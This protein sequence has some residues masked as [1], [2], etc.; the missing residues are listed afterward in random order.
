MKVELSDFG[1]VKKGFS[2]ELDQDEILSETD[3]V[4]R[5]LAARV[6][7]P[8]FRA[9]KAPLSVIRTRFASEIESDVVESLVAR[10]HAEAAEK[11]GLRPL[12][13]PVIEDLNHD[14]GSSLRFRTTFEV[15]PEVAPKGYRGVEVREPAVRITVE[16]VEKA[17][18]ELRD[19][20][21]KL[22]VEE[23]R[24]ARTG[25]VIVA[26]I[27][28]VPASGEPFRRERSL[29]EVGAQDNLP[30]F[31]ERIDGAVAGSLL[32]FPVR[33]PEDYPASHLAGQTVQYKL[34]IHE[35]KTRQLPPL[36]DDFARDLGDFAGLDALRERIRQDLEQARR[37][38]A[39]RAVRAAVLDKV[40]LEN[41]IPLPDVL[42]E[43]EVQARLQDM[44]LSLMMQGVDPSK[45]KVDWKALRERQD[46]PA[47]KA[48]HARLVL[49]AIAKI[50]GIDASSGEVEAWFRAE[51]ARRGEGMEALR[52]RISK[53]GG[54]QVIHH[55]LVREKSL[56]FLTSV[57]NIQRGE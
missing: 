51:A 55:Q 49:D 32:E 9:G 36:D 16:D 18:G 45:I 1:P 57:A 40:L 26:D 19:A 29:I 54:E 42:V 31:N 23:G 8:G 48:V 20:H 35:V 33:Y 43:E 10:F 3:A 11:E 38:D 7:I 44:V 52:A 22:V 17:L 27:E 2:I 39:K 4:V 46:E 56:D 12:R 24:T 41:P 25:D 47:R 37:A 6:R 21:T 13:A 53:E 30:E 28:G 14:K 15:L 50:E 34:T 5:R